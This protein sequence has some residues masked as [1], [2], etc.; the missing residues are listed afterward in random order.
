M[1]P[2]PAPLCKDEAVCVGRPTQQA[3]EFERFVAFRARGQKAGLLQRVRRADFPVNSVGCPLRF[4]THDFDSYDDQAQQKPANRRPFI[5]SNGNSLIP[6]I[7]CI[8]DV[9]I[10]SLHRWA[11]SLKA[12]N[13]LTRNLPET[14]A[15]KHKAKHTAEPCPT[16]LH[17]FICIQT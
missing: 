6:C 14:T 3:C 1:F 16:S 4:L 8:Y 11:G 5:D 2:R 17:G 12:P 13:T 9:S 15:E 10:L 7:S